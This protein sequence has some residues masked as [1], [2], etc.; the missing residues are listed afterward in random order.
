[1]CG[2][3]FS[4]AQWEAWDLSESQRPGILVIDDDPAVA[5]VLELLLRD[6]GC[7]VWVAAEGRD[8]LALYGTH[9]RHIS[10]V[11][12]DVRMPD[13]D[14]PQTL[15][16]LRAIDPHVVCCFMSGDSGEY[17]EEFLKQTAI[18]LLRKPFG[19]AE[20][21]RLLRST[22]PHFTPGQTP[23]ERRRQQRV[24]AHASEVLVFKADSAAIPLHGVVLDRSDAGICLA[25]EQAVTAG[26]ILNVCPPS[27]SDKL[28]RVEIEVKYCDPVGNQWRVGGELKQPLSAALLQ[29]LG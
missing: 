16:A 7:E 17:T 29:V 22:H 27:I 3:V 13:M 12:L 1:M 4:F 6:L 14:G 5:M 20:I 2:S 11:L 25:I 10:L 23:R 21:E 19:T 9:R 18:G 28:P 26:D 24:P 8:G 15:Q